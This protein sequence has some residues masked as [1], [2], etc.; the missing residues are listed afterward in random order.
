MKKSRA[1]NGTSEFAELRMVQFDR[2]ALSLHSEIEHLHEDGK[3]HR[4]IRVSLRNVK[5][6][7]FRDQVHPN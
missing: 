1:I 7:T 6:R 4:E 3:T 5:T 2:G